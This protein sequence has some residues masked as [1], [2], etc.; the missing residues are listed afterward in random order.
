MVVRQTEGVN[1]FRDRGDGAAM[2]RMHR[3]VYRTMIT[4]VMAVGLLCTIQAANADAQQIVA[5][6]FEDLGLGSA[7]SYVFAINSAT[8]APVG[9][10]T[11]YFPQGPG[12]AVGF[13]WGLD[14]NFLIMAFSTTTDILELTGYDPNIDVLFFASRPPYYWAGCQS[15]YIPAA[16]PRDIA[17]YLCSFVR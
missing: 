13:A 3:L 16:V 4:M 8:G 14:G 12:T 9:V 1:S 15:P 6:Y 11:I 7:N 2:N 17:S 5:V 10:R